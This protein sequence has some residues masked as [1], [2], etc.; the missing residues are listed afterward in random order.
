MDLGSIVKTDELFE[1]ELLHPAT[2]EPLGV[3]FMIRSHESAE[4]QRVQRTHADKMLA[5]GGKKLTTGKMKAQYLDQAAASIASWDW[6]DHEIDG[7]Q[8]EYSQKKAVEILEK[9]AWIYD[10]V[11][12]ASENRANFIKA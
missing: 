7:E 5:S 10:Q 6:G 9:H 1:L 2:D 12:G 3:V 8:P 4:V 11:A